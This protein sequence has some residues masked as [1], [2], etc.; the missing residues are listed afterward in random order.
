MICY[1]DMTFCTAYPTR[2]A[3]SVCRRSLTDEERVKAMEWS[4]TFGIH[5]LLVAF[6]DFSGR[7]NSIKQPQES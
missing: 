2:C 3:N 6:A 7:C 5:D 1:R 4:K